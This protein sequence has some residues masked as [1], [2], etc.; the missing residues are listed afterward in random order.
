MYPFIEE[1]T[2]YLLIQIFTKMG[3][4][5][6]VLLDGAGSAGS[7]NNT[8]ANGWLSMLPGLF[9]NAFGGNKMDPNLVA[10][11]MNGRNNQDNFGGQGA[12][13]MWILLLFFLRGGRGFGDW[14]NGGDPCCHGIPQGLNNSYGHELLMQAIQGNRSATEQLASQFNCSVQQVQSALCAIQGSIDKVAGQVGMTSQAVINAIQSTGCQIGNQI[15]QCC[16]NLQGLINQSTCGLQDSIT[17]QGYEGQLATLNQT[18]QLQNTIN[19]GFSNNREVSTSQFNILSSKIDAQTTIIND[20]FCELEKREMQ[21]TIDALREEKQTLQLFAAQQ[22]QTKAIVDQVR[23][24]PIPS[25]NV[26]NP[27]GYYGGFNGYGFNGGCC[28]NNS[29]NGCGNGYCNNGANV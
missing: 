23:P 6:I 8:A 7:S 26:C 1:R 20:K 22:A 27:W 9:V 24:C 21:H 16:C 3:G 18:N 2:H 4:D 25:F 15:S 19:N 28:S 13:W 11:L 12:W 17:R 14:G 29:C 5:K 10:A